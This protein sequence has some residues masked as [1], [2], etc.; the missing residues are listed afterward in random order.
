MREYRPQLLQIVDP[1]RRLAERTHIH[2]RDGVQRAVLG[3]CRFQRL[4]RIAPARAEGIAGGLG[5]RCS[6]RTRVGP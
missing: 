2:S 6:Q 4:Q 3:T 5:Q 1:L